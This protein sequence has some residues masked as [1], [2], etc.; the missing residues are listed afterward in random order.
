L[1]VGGGVLLGEVRQDSDAAV[2]QADLTSVD[3]GSIAPDLRGSVTGRVSLRGAGD[4]LS[5][6]ANV[7]LMGLRSIDAPRGLT[8]DGGLTATLV[9]NTLRLQA[10]ASGTNAVNATADVTLP[11][12][13]SAAPLRLAIARTRPM[14]GEVDIDGQIQ[15]IWDVFF[16]GERSLAGQVNASATLGGTLAAP[17][18]NGS[19]ALA[20]GRFRDN[21]S[22]LTLDDMTVAARFHDRPD[23]DL[24]C[25]RQLGRHGL[26]RWP[27]RSA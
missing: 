18:I 25:H 21:S 13:A 10:N 19:L 1:T 6:S 7:R 16:G 26:R 11:V 9:N 22:G 14:S 24:H 15:P 23:P 8:V 17:L 4:D 3:L 12:E 5:G 20:Q 2:V 27:H